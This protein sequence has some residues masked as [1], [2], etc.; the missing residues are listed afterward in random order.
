M[1]KKKTQLTSKELVLKKYPLA[2]VAQILNNG[3]CVQVRVS[4]R[5][6]CKCCG[7]IG[8]KTLG[9]G[10]TEEWAGYNASTFIEYSK[11]EN[12]KK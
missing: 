3:F 5:D 11:S 7:N 10:F 4:D 8:I 2:Y 6:R 1:G 12:K 9:E